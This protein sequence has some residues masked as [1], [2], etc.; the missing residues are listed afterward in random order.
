MIRGK[1]YG[2]EFTI[3][4]SPAPT[5]SVRVT[6]A[7]LRVDHWWILYPGVEVYE[8]NE[9]LSVLPLRELEVQISRLSGERNRILIPGPELR[10]VQRRQ[11]RGFV[12]TSNWLT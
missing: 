2:F 1:R 5:R 12:R 6:L 4:E 11:T 7:D 8:L 9:R 3:A 10:R